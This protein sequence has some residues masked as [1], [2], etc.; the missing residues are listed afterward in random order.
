MLPGLVTG[1]SNDYNIDH[2][3]HQNLIE[4]TQCFSVLRVLFH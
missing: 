3:L 1:V 4:Y 2:W